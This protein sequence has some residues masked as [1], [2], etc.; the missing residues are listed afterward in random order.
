MGAPS[1]FYRSSRLPVHLTFPRT[2]SHPQPHGAA[3]HRRRGEAPPRRLG[4]R[5]RARAH[6]VLQA[7]EGRHDAL[8]CR[9][10]EGCVPLVCSSLSGGCTNL[11]V[12]RRP[13]GDWRGCH[14]CR[15]VRAQRA[16]TAAFPSFT[17]ISLF[18]R[19]Q[20]SP[21][22]S[23]VHTVDPF[24]AR[25]S[26]CG[27]SLAATA[28]PSQDAASPARPFPLFRVSGGTHRYR[29]G[30]V[31]AES[32]A[33]FDVPAGQLRRRGV[34]F[35]LVFLES[36]AVLHSQ[37]LEGGRS[38]FCVVDA[39]LRCCATL[40][41]RR[42]HGDLRHRLLSRSSNPHNPLT[43]PADRGP[44]SRSGSAAKSLITSL[45]NEGTKVPGSGP[46][47]KRVESSLDR[48]A[49]RKVYSS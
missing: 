13:P 6:V 21:R 43:T 28:G 15:A 31:L 18:L 46:G 11:V 24:D 12:V 36:V 10:S 3:Q 33:P 2:R 49:A 40:S 26:L 23:L 29:A 14:A 19:T 22:F 39:T 1:S 42:A 7:Q 34:L 41:L 45:G 16:S 27:L 44:A 17:S 4:R 48:R 9:D 25:Y 8:R 32:Y 47:L 5:A 30:I 37:W 38:L 20:T 35:V